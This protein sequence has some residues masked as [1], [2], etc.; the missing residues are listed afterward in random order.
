MSVC[1][2]PRLIAYNMCLTALAVVL[3]AA[4]AAAA[5]SVLPNRV[6][7]YA[8]LAVLGPVK[9]NGFH[10]VSQLQGCGFAVADNVFLGL[11]DT[12]AAP[13]VV[14]EKDYA[15]AHEAPVY[16]PRLKEIFFVS[17]RLG[18]TSGTSQY[19]QL[20]TLDL[21]SN[22][23]TTLASL[24]D[25]LPLANG[26]TN[27]PGTEDTIAL[28]TQGKGD[29][30]PGAINKLNLKTLKFETILDN[31][32]GRPF[33]SPNDLAF[34][35]DGRTLFFTDPPYGFAQKFKPAPE[36]GN[37]VYAFDTVS[38]I[39]RVAADGFVKPNG[40]AFSPDFKTAY[41][42]DTGMADVSMSGK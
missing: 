28:L 16:L 21:A 41:V 10:P 19:I 20:N 30:Q 13:T 8:S 32:F 24:T 34:W 6:C 22:K 3:V 14:A 35:R 17:N 7:S 29:W 18:D 31:Y 42:T 37:Y 4:S 36:L 26:A 27:W 33:N 40:F 2:C 12:S 23:V 5:Q 39:V 25:I 1:P 9:R 15:F 38:K 11:V